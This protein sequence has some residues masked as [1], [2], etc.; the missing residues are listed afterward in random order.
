LYKARQGVLV[1]AHAPYGY[2]YVPKRDGVPAHLEIDPEEAEGVRQL[3]DWLINEQLSTLKIAQRLRASRWKTRRGGPWRD[4]MV[5]HILRNECY[6]GRRYY[7]KTETVE[8]KKRRNPR[9][10]VKNLKSSHAMRPREE[11]IEISPDK[12]F[13]LSAPCRDAIF[14]APETRFRTPNVRP[15]PR[16]TGGRPVS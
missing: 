8:P 11:W 7:N 15:N 5:H 14:E 13:R 4:T 16:R 10:Y 12:K 1:A 6:T 3:F 2:R 9:G